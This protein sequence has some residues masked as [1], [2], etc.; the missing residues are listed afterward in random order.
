MIII[1][2]VFVIMKTRKQNNDVEVEN[3]DSYIKAWLI[4]L[5]FEIN[6]IKLSQFLINIFFVL[7]K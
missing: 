5:K 6:F 3:D 7:D 1:I 2:L 4:E